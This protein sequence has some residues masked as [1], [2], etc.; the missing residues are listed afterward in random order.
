MDHLYR[1]HRL[2]ECPRCFRTFGKK[3]KLDDHHVKGCKKRDR[4][5]QPAED[6]IDEDKLKRLQC[7]KGLSALDEEGKFVRIYRILFPDVAEVPSPC[8]AIAL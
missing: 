8:K 4:P 3:Q 7:K 2:H 1:C 5:K 6:G